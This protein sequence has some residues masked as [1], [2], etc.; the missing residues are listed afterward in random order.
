VFR[1]DGHGKKMKTTYHYKTR[2]I[3]YQVINI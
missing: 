3:N 2:V 1:Y